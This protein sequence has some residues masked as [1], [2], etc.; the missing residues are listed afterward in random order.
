MISKGIVKFNRR[1]KYIRL[2]TSLD[3]TPLER[4][5]DK[6]KIIY[7]E[8]MNNYYIPNI[9]PR[10]YIW[11]YKI[12]VDG[13]VIDKDSIYEHFVFDRYDKSEFN[14]IKWI[15][16][17]FIKKLMDIKKDSVDITIHYRDELFYKK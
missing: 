1:E 14:T 12:E 4:K 9:I 8:E 11:M 7:L 13:E 5:F 2:D 10:P 3:T 17:Y 15:F 16:I 6:I